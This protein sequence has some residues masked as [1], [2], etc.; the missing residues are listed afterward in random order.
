MA[1]DI[2][3]KLAKVLDTLPNGF[4]ATES[5]IE[6]KLLKKV[7]T[8][9][10]AEFFCDLRLK[11]ET[12]DQIAERT[13]RPIEGLEEKL[14]AMWR[15]GEIFGVDLGGTK[16]FKMIPWVLGIY[17]YQVKR[18]DREF[19]ELNEAYFPYF[20]KQFFENEPQYMQVVPIGQSITS[21]H[22]ALPYEQVA[23]I[24]ESGQSFAVADCIC[25]KEK[26]LLDQR[27]DK[28]MEVCLAIAPI[29]NVLDDF[30]H[31]GSPITKEDAYEILKISEEAGLVHLTHNVQTG[32]FFICN[33]CGCCCGILRGINELGATHAINSRFYA[34]IDPESCI[35]CG[36]C[37]EERC[38]VNAIE[39][40]EDAYQVI[41]EKCI[42]CGLCVTTCPT[43]SIKLIAK[44]AEEYALPPNDEKDWLAER[45]ERRG[46][47]FS[48]L[49]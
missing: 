17:E 19:A 23:N 16:L 5:G 39:E 15:R 36:T 10:E 33:C 35:A 29:P 13:G 12:V 43:E 26:S 11:L 34:Q 3:R 42:G 24:I 41:Q 48:A 27:C 28:P 37:Y 40:G 49:K 44:K 38:Q 30:T 4:P 46:V 32:H 1:D 21:E 47:D 18:M 20:G 7:F 9:E 45:G 8:P 2:Y 22:Q 6:I 14:T 31:W 25:K